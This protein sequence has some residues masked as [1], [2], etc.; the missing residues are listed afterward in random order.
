MLTAQQPFDIPEKNLIKVGPIGRP[1]LGMGRIFWGGVL[2]RVPDLLGPI[3]C[4]KPGMGRFWRNFDFLEG[5]DVF[6]N[7][8][9]NW[10]DQDDI[11]YG[12]PATYKKNPRLR[13]R[14][15]QQTLSFS[16]LPPS[17]KI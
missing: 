9:A 7:P 5:L 2:V 11:R 1:K 10:K 12:K 6:L 14:T 16:Q 8:R 3:G 4:P 15:K 13:A 17:G